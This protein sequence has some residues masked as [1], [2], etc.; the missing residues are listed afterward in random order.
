MVQ[1]D[2]STHLCAGAGEGDSKK[3]KNAGNFVMLRYCSCRE[4]I[5]NLI[6][7]KNYGL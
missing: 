3:E 6:N 2:L 7:V 5:I 1:E 4:M